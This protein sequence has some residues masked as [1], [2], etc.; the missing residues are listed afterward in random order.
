MDMILGFICDKFGK[1][2]A[3]EIA[4]RIEYIWNDNPREDIFAKLF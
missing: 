4:E 1:E 3:K 2:K